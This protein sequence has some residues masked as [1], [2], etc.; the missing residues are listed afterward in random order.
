MKRSFVLLVLAVLL[1]ALSLEGRTRSTSKSSP[2]PQSLTQTCTSPMFPDPS[3]LGIDNQCANPGNGGDEAAQNTAKNNFCPTTASPASLTVAQLAQL[4]VTAGGNPDIHFGSNNVMT[5]RDPLSSLGEGKLVSLKAYVFKARQEGGESVNCK[6]HVP[7][8]D[9]FHDIHISLV[10]SA[11]NQIKSGDNQA[12][13]NRKECTG[14]VA[15]MSPHH[16]PANWTADNVNKLS[17]SATMV[18]VTG[19]QFFD[20]SHVPCIN[21]APVGSNPKRVSLWEI[22]PTYKFEVCATRSCTGTGARWQS[23]DRWLARHP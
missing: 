10:S 22:H 23:L 2:H 14:V 21:G 3:A 13:K 9:A 1:V 12:T 20:S 15:E 19:Q 18:R 16:R 8:D 17:T 6:G 11:Q 4:Q 5:D 7:D